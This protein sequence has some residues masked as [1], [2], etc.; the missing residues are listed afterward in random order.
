[1]RRLGDLLQSIEA[2]RPYVTYA[3]YAYTFLSHHEVVLSDGY[4]II[5]EDL[6]RS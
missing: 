3:V 2:L 1:M 5:P 6:D 4:R